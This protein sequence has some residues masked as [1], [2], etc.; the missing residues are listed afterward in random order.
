MEGALALQQEKRREKREGR[1]YE[2]TSFNHTSDSWT[3]LD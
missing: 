2:K 1:I 3:D